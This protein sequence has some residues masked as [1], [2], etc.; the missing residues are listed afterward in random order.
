M[1]HQE[2]MLEIL[3]ARDRENKDGSEASVILGFLNYHGIIV[4]KNK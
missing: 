3:T 1:T 2:Q 4:E